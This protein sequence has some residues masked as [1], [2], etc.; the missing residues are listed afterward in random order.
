MF[1]D[2]GESVVGPDSSARWVKK[3][4]R[5][6]A[7]PVETFSR[8]KVS[9]NLVPYYFGCVLCGFGA[10]GVLAGFAVGALGLAAAGLVGAGT[11]DCAL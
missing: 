9:Q 7:R 11:P 4:G 1:M 10:A 8:F 3:K 5:I 6:M 2:T